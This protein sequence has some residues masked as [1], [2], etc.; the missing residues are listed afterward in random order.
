MCGIAG[1]YCLEAPTDTVYRILQM[2]KHRGPDTLGLL[3]FDSIA[4]GANRLSISGSNFAPSPMM[5]EHSDIVLAYNGEIYGL[6]IKENQSD[7]G[8]LLRYLENNP[9]SVPD[10]NGMF[11]MCWVD[12][13]KKKLAVARDFFGIKP[14][15]I[16]KSP[17]RF[18]FSSEIFPLVRVNE[19]HPV[20]DEL[21]CLE[22]IGLGTRV[23]SDTLFSNIERLEPGNILYVEQKKNELHYKLRCP[24]KHRL[25]RDTIKKDL[26]Q[27]IKESVLLCADTNRPLGV[28][29]S[30][31]VD[32]M[33]IVYILAEAGIDNLHTF[34]LILDN[35][36]I[37]N[38]EQLSLP[39]LAWRKWKHTPITVTDADV[40]DLF[41]R[42]LDITSQPCF[43]PSAAYTLLLSKV[44]AENGVKVVLSGE[45]SDELFGG[46]DSYISFLR[47]DNPDPC[48]FYLNNSVFRTALNLFTDSGEYYIEMLRRKMS[49]VY[50]GKKPLSMQLLALERKLSLQ[51]LLERIDHA[52]MYFSIE[53]RTPFL[54][55]DV[56]IIAW[57]VLGEFDPAL[58]TK[59]YL[60][61]ALRPLLHDWANVPKRPLRISL[62]SWFQGERL[63]SA[64]DYIISDPYLTIVNKKK[65]E[66]F[67]NW[68]LNH[69][70]TSELM[71]A[72]RMYQLLS[73]LNRIK[74]DSK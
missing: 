67:V 55:G 24:Q 25:Y 26:L 71:V 29:L 16:W 56:P 52:S 68:L 27:A 32:S 70:N 3:Q 19:L 46:Y 60:R 73:Y 64:V 62:D 35:D 31:G 15:Y 1:E 8:W 69:P 7:T 17:Q 74:G 39:G 61:R 5:A 72:I 28:F 36:G 48:N 4:I 43:P 54:H 22:Y 2:Q 45:G 49:S 23:G 66:Q 13:K 47:T 18:Q 53:V 11:S 33:A 20:L 59:P 38:L 41:H 21:A 57:N 34:S 10:L 40:W 14:L 58:G 30:S 9:L 42:F 51:P 37:E 12:V 65:W 6:S 50:E 63:R 44:A